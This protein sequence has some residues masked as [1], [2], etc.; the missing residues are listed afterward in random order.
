MSLLQQTLAKITAP[1][2]TVAQQ[3]QER[4]DRLTRPGALGLLGSMYSRYAGIT[5]ELRPQPPR[6]CMV[7]ACADHGVA[8]HGISAYP[9]ETTLHMTT[10]YLMSKGASANAF[11]N[12]SRSDM[13]V[14][15]VGVA[16]D[17]SHVPGLWQRSIAPGTADFTKGPAMTRA[18]AI[19][20]IETGIE[21]V[22]DRVQQGYNCFSLGEMGIGNTSSSAA[23]V[24]AFT[25][26]DPAVVAG[27]GTGI[28][29]SRMQVKLN[30]IRQ[31]LA[32][33]CPDPEDGIDVLAKVGGFELGA[34]AGVVLAGAA[35]RC[36]IVIDGSNTTASALIADSIHPLCRQYLFASHLSG[37]P[38][39][40]HA[41]ARLQIKPCVDMGIRL[42]EAIGASVVVDMLAAD[43]VTQQVL[44]NPS[45]GV[46][47]LAPAAVDPAAGHTLSDTVARI[48]PLDPVAMEACQLRI[49]NLTKPLAS[50]NA[51]EHLAR[52]L[53]G[54]TGNPRPKNLGK[55]VIVI[56]DGSYAG[57]P[58]V[59]GFAK[60]ADAG[61]TFLEMNAAA[62]V[63]RPARLTR[64]QVVAAIEKGIAAAAAIG[65]RVNIVGLG[66]LNRDTRP[67]AEWVESGMP[68]TFDSED[69]ALAMLE[70]TG[71]VVLAGLTGVILGAAASG[72]AVVLDDLE[73]STAALVATA[74]A[75][76]SRSYLI[77][78]HRG[79]D[80]VQQSVLD[81]LELPAYLDLE[82][83]LGDGTGAV[84]G[85]RLV[86][87]S[88]HMLNDMKTFGE[89]AVAV[90]QDGPGA[91]RQDPAVK[92]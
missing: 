12:F 57:K 33:N 40:R 48:K 43:A 64:E 88:M 91:L 27:R 37:E 61:L 89:A 8:V 92:D 23:I 60:H 84:L 69:A 68:L 32:V 21:I 63:F 52:Q 49:D 25:Q 16:G 19:Q 71:S 79:V 14:V 72:A 78:S 29:D 18:Q 73:T 31:G 74:I 4:I 3:V 50:L 9:V 42:G 70:Q 30:V 41:L 15:D 1:D 56:S 53:A 10:N 22:N 76:L 82:L 90:A 66:V 65:R 11:A 51:F 28:S 75:P 58:A 86:D 87:A 80:P 77:P 7:V 62:D 39:H 35:H 45:I 5:G 44:A 20:A 13:V 55:A 26:L 81:T 2:L 83:A 85:I 47:E 54:I 34:L 24:A 17:L 38:A 59:T 36:A 46:S 67:I 6:T